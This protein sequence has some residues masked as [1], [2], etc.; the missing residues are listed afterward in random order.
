MLLCQYASVRLEEK[1]F[2]W[3]FY[4]SALPTS[5]GKLTTRRC[6]TENKEYEI[7]ED[8]LL[9]DK[10]RIYVPNSRELRNLVLKE[11]HDVPYVDILVTIKQLQQ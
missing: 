3:Y 5:K 2:R 4:R 11:M 1:N 8:R 10:N 7:K 6:T 9:M